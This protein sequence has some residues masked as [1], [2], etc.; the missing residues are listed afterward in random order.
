MRK[1]TI[2]WSLFLLLFS[3]F[4]LAQDEEGRALYLEAKS[5]YDEGNGAGCPRAVVL[6][7]QYLK[8]YKP[9]SGMATK[10]AGAINWCEGFLQDQERYGGESF[11]AHGYCGNIPV[12]VCAELLQGKPKLYEDMKVPAP[13][14]PDSA[15]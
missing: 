7:K 5:A 4:C 3:S 14:G 1:L 11:K 15:K 8:S 2:S 13:A 9:P 6:L 12:G 10:I